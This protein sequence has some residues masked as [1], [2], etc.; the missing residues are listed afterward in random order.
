MSEVD[1]APVENLSA[2]VSAALRHAASVAPRFE[3]VGIVHE[4]VG[5]VLKARGL[6]GKAALP[7]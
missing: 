3:E 4:A 7:V 5:T 1:D 2:Q 6:H